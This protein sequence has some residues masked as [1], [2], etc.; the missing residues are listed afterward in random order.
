MVIAKLIPTEG[1]AASTGSMRRLGLR[2]RL[3][4]VVSCLRLG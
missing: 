1:S 2:M 3:K 4:G